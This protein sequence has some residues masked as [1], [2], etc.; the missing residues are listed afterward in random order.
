MYQGYVPLLLF[1]AQPVG[2]ALPTTVGVREKAALF[3]AADTREGRAFSLA[4][5]A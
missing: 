1:S 5:D 2:P 3:V 4:A